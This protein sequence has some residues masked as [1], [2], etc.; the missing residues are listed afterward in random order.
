MAWFY[1]MTGDADLVEQQNPAFIE[2]LKSVKFSRQPAPAGA[3]N[4]ATHA[5][6]TSGMGHAAAAAPGPISHEGQ[7]TGR[8]R[9]AGRKFPADNFSSPNSTLPA[10][11]ARQRRST[12]A[13]NGDGGGLSA[14]VNR[15]RG[16]LGLQPEHGNVAAP[17]DVTGGKARLVDISGISPQT[18]Q[19]AQLV[20]VI[21]SQAGQTWFY[22]LMGDA[23]VVAAQKDAFIQ[24]VQSAKYPEMLIKK[25]VGFFSSLKLTV[26]LLAFAI[27][28]VF[29]GTLA[30]VDE[31]LYAAQAHYFR[32]WL[33]I[34]AHLSAKIPL[35]L[36]GG[37]LI[38]M[39]LLVNLVSAHIYRF[40]LTRKKIGIQLAHAGVI[41]LLV[42]QLATDM[43]SREMQ[44]HFA[45]GQ[46]RSYSESATDSELVFRTGDE[47]TAIPAKLL[48]P[49]DELKIDK[50][51]FAIRV[52]SFW[53]NSDLSFRAPMM[54][55]APPLTTNGLA[56][57]FDFQQSP[58]VKSMDER[59]VP[60]AII[61]LAGPNGSL[62]DWV[63]SDW[64]G[65]DALVEAIRNDYANQM[66]ADMAQKIIAELV[67]PQSV[68]INGKQF[69][70]VMRPARVPSRFR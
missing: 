15:W 10:T 16:Q 69:T 8:C 49:G 5:P 9:P 25:I 26:V 51:P 45:E 19:P 29:V 11:T 60:T 55:N 3:G 64:A 4:A 50:L 42:G 36:P 17:L 18:S 34:G 58:D 14:N 30:Q 41:L 70:F 43:L 33:V 52:K 67:Q 12:S 32:Q 44:M 37:Y 62:G 56:R 68:E 53:Q 13:S 54:Q 39:V 66:G 65:D 24:F 48:K 40:Q 20:A 23:K 38:G 21:V 2:F 47:V 61:E 35:I 63:V 22:K 27:V 6:A 59:N 28:L 57:S 1:K 7:P 31:G 46:T